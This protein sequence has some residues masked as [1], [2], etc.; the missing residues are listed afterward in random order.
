MNAQE[1]RQSSIVVAVRV[2][3]FT[4]DESIHLIRDN[5]DS[6]LYPTLT[7]STLTL[8]GSRENNN[9]GKSNKWKSVRA[10]TEIYLSYCDE[11][12]LCFWIQFGEKKCSSELYTPLYTY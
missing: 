2:R 7:D 8:P 6:V 11:I 12:E 5:Y 9:N 1:S 4:N 3:P 10:S